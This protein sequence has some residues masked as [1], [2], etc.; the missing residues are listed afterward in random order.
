MYICILDVYFIKP[1][2]VTTHYNQSE[3]FSDIWFFTTRW[4]RPISS[5]LWLLSRLCSLLCTCM[6]IPYW[7]KTNTFIPH[8]C[9]PI[10]CTVCLTLFQIQITNLSCSLVF[11]WYQSLYWF[12]RVTRTKRT[13][14]PQNVFGGKYVPSQQRCISTYLF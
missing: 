11:Q 10:P 4:Y 12:S 6:T 8:A 1:Q 7:N 14:W 13:L 2:T 5:V 3:F 9:R